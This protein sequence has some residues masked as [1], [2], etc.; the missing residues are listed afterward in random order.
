MATQSTLK[1]SGHPQ[2]DGRKTQQA[3]FE[4][5]VLKIMFSE[6]AFLALRL[7]LIGLCGKLIHSVYVRKE[8]LLPHIVY[9]WSLVKNNPFLMAIF[10]GSIIATPAAVI[11][12]VVHPL[13]FYIKSFFV[14]KV[15]IESSDPS[16]VKVRDY[17]MELPHHGIAADSNL[18]AVTKKAN[19]LQ[20]FPNPL[21]KFDKLEKG[22]VARIIRISITH[23]FVET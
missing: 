17:I 5:K 12:Y 2:R 4:Q 22:W 7:A 16:F 3:T 21:L 14:A 6:R 20:G 18:K 1:S 9:C 13:W 19:L 10:G 15:T 11:R 23:N 8:W